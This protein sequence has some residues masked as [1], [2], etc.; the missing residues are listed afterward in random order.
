[1]KRGCLNLVS[2]GPGV[3]E[4]ITGAALR[5][6]A[7]SDVIVAYDLYLSWIRSDI[8]E[9]TIITTPLSQEK[10][11]VQKAIDAARNGSRVALI[12]SGDIGIYAMATL[13]FELMSETDTFAVEVF[14]G[15]TAAVAGAALLGAPLSHDFATLSLSDL[16]C[17]WQWIEERARH[18][19][20]ADLCVAL[21]NVQSRKR[22]EG[23]YRIIEILV[24][25]K[26]AGTLCGIVRNAYRE[27]Q[28]FEI[29]TLEELGKRT[30]DMFTTIFVGNRH[31]RRKREWIFTPRGYGQWQE[32]EPI[33][34]VLASTIAAS[35]SFPQKAIWL[36]SG[37]QD[38]NALASSLVNALP[39]ATPVVVSVA[40]EYGGELALQ[41]PGITVVAGKIGRTARRNLLEQCQAKVIVDATHPFADKISEQLIELSNEL[42]LSY[43]R[44]ERPASP[45]TDYRQARVCNDFTEAIKLSLTVGKR[46]FLATGTKGL[47]ELASLKSEASEQPLWFARVTASPDSIEK[48]IAAGI[49]LSRICAMQGP[50]DSQF[51]QALWKQWQ[52]DCVI[53]KESGDVGGTN[54]KI[55]AAESLGI[56]I[57]IVRRP[58]I[59]YPE[60][61]A[62][63]G[64][65]VSRVLKICRSEGAKV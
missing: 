39:P 41:V 23:V 65:L 2:V 64:E 46:I 44:Y 24:S 56:P 17:P 63:Q 50:F 28:S 57:L 1:M 36:F 19:A 11:R 33:A 20:A 21:Y 49:P 37:T 40:T 58:H 3:K 60:V 55:E 27:D 25:H 8:S 12:S 18:I 59:D 51:N 14:P 53:T 32:K 62:S 5:A 54:A 7:E 45:P 34:D 16:M 52:I 22:Q 9:K 42:N 61:F 47:S 48:T 26:A 6:I 31:T 35:H 43:L 30:F 15:V 10:E 4:Q 13:A 38:G 29:V